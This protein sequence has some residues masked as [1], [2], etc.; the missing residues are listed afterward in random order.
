MIS[1]PDCTITPT[2]AR[3][4]RRQHDRWVTRRLGSWD[5]PD[6]PRR[7]GPRVR[8]EHA[9]LC[10]LFGADHVR[11]VDYDK[12]RTHLYFADSA[13]K[14]LYRL[15]ASTVERR[16][17]GV[18]GRCLEFPVA[19][20]G[21]AY[22]RVIQGLARTGYHLIDV[23]H[24]VMTALLRDVGVQHEAS[25]W[26]DGRPTWAQPGTARIWLPSGLALVVVPEKGDAMV[27]TVVAASALIGPNRTLWETLDR[28]ENRVSFKRAVM[29]PVVRH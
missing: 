24:D 15:Y 10:A 13:A 1:L 7:F 19:A 2:H 5:P 18:S 23:L 17:D 11:R 16:P 26:A 3:G 27:R 6:M 28:S 20:T 12:R 9:Q 8:A 25:E 21:H 14:G 4:L 29:P 22:E